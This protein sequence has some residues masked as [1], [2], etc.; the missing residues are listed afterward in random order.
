MDL[1]FL[2]SAL[3]SS[4]A[5]HFY[6]LA[7]FYAFRIHS[8][9]PDGS[10]ILSIVNILIMNKEYHRGSHWAAQLNTPQGRY[11]HALCMF[12]SNKPSETISILQSSLSLDNCLINDRIPHGESGLYLLGLAYKATGRGDQADRIFGHLLVRNPDHYGAL[13]HSST[14]HT[15]SIRSIPPPPSFNSPP[16]SSRPSTVRSHLFTPPVA[17]S[18]RSAFSSIKTTPSTDQT[19]EFLQQDPMS[20]PDLDQVTPEHSQSSQPDPLTD[21]DLNTPTLPHT[22]ITQPPPR[23]STHRTARSQFSDFEETP[24]FSQG[25]SSLTLRPSTGLPPSGLPSTGFSFESDTRETLLFPRSVPV[26]AR[27]R[28]SLSVFSDI[29]SSISCHNHSQS[30]Q[31]ISSLSQSNQSLADVVLLKSTALMQQCRYDEAAN[32]LLVTFHSDPWTK[33]IPPLACCFWAMNNVT[34]LRALVSQ[35][36]LYYPNHSVVHFARANLFSLEKKFGQAAQYFSLAAQS[37][38]PLDTHFKALCLA[39]KG[40]ELVEADDVALSK[41]EFINSLAVDP[42]CLPALI[43]LSSAEVKSGRLKHAITFLKRALKVAPKNVVVLNELGH[44]MFLIYEADVT[45]TGVLQESVKYYELGLSLDAGNGPALIGL[46]KCMIEQQEFDRARHLIRK[47]HKIDP[48]EIAVAKT[49]CRL[50]LAV[51]DNDEAYT[52]LLKASVLS[53]NDP[54]VLGLMKE[55]EEH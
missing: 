38:C 29:V 41:E 1:S 5:D 9:N 17:K 40:L 28:D 32:I 37:A 14:S 30:L 48:R 13:T 27:K 22:P 49:G 3:D 55:F 19:P 52:W 26:D 33:L 12:H 44:V 16:P 36:D 6:D 11:L 24:L 2:Q 23:R 46:A 31:S 8:C 21:R 7:L 4:L 53:P 45:N 34:R 25:S 50:E 10:S 20:S 51:G 43:G 35:S 42:N 15:T 18:S 39:S 54:Y 47:A